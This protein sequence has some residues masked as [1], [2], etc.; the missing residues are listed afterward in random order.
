MQQT[1]KAFTLVE[2]LVVIAIIGVLIVLLL[3]AVQAVR[4]SARRSRCQ[5][6]IKQIAL[7]C[8]NHE[9]AHKYLP[10]G[11]WAYGWTGD[12]DRG[13]GLAQPGGWIYNL[14]PF[15]EE[16]AIRSIGA[17]ETFEK[18]KTT[19]QQ[20]ATTPISLFSCATR[21]P[22]ILYRFAPV[23]QRFNMFSPPKVARGDYAINAGNQNRCEIY[24]GPSTLSQGMNAQYQ[25]PD[26]SDHTGVS[27]QRSLIRSAQITDGTTKTYL[28][29]E[30]YIDPKKYEN[31]TCYADNAYMLTGYNND[32]HRSTY[33]PPMQDKKGASHTD[34]F[35][36]AHA[37]SFVMSMCDGSVRSVEYDVDPAVHRSMGHRNDGKPVSGAGL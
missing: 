24:Y 27:Y 28:V 18:K 1:N 12:P 20:A 33:D 16:P 21:R 23:Q 6:N 10:C 32:H 3:P 4:E 34:R 7:A 8:L 2:L 9:Q 14:L 22:A 36:S 35:G 13:F 37:G 25:W 5:S 30:R 26:I 11:G 29:G 17:G 31:G 15:I 19:L